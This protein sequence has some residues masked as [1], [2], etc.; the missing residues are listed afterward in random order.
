MLFQLCLSYNH[1]ESGHQHDGAVAGV[2]EHD[3]E[4]EGKGGDGEGRRV[5]LTVGVQAVCVNQVLKII[6]V[7]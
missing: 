1:G 6:T 7:K 3:S 4:Q 5:H 2:A